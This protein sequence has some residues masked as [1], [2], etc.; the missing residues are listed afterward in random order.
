VNISCTLTT[1]D[2]G[3]QAKRWQRLRA[4]AGIERL[5]TDDGLQLTFHDDVGIENELRALAAVENRCC[6]WARWEVSRADGTLVLEIRST[7]DGV[8]VVHGMFA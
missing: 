6:S 7:G 2:L 8:A 4:E 5:A 1:K 3:A